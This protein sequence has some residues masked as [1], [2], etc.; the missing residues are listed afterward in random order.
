CTATCSRQGFQ[1]RIL[2]CVWYGSSR[3]AGNACRDQQRPIVM[4]PCKGPPCQSSER[5]LH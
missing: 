3:P 2:Q 5:Q 4:R 1:S